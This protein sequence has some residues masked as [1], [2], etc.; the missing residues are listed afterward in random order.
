MP[1]TI[2]ETGSPIGQRM[3]DITM[4]AGAAAGAYGAHRLGVFRALGNRIVGGQQSS[5]S[6]ATG[7]H[8]SAQPNSQGPRSMP[9]Q[10]LTGG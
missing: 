9:N 4:G 3:S 1:I 7:N 8:S 6:S 5:P 10:K 2:S